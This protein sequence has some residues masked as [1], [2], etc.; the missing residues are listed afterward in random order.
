M[1]WREEK[2]ASGLVEVSEAEEEVAEET[3]TIT[4][5]EAVPATT[6]AAVG[7]AVEAVE[8]V[9][10]AAGMTEMTCTTQA[11]GKQSLSRV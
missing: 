8:G 3:M 4:T 7:E 1:K 9:A 10:S 2:T 5:A 11:T 6:T